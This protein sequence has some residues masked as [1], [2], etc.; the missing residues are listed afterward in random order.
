VKDLVLAVHV[1]RSILGQPRPP[2]RLRF[3]TPDLAA[4]LANAKPADIIEI[5]GGRRITIYVAR[6]SGDPIGIRFSRR[7]GGRGT[8]YAFL[9]REQLED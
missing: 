3:E 1:A 9:Q 7:A 2:L 8:V 6:Y 5:T 4:V